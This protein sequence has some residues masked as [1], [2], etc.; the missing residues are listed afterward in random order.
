MN[1]VEIEQVISELAELP[2]DRAE[3]P[4][5]FLEAFGSKATFLSSEAFDFADVHAANVD[6]SQRFAHVLKL[7]W[8]DDREDEFH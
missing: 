4:F 5:A 2:F 8:F 3:F 7:G 6:R 1:A